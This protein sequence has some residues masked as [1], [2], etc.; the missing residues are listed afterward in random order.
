MF[1]VLLNSGISDECDQC[2]AVVIALLGAKSGYF[3]GDA[4]QQCNESFYSCINLDTE[5]H[6]SFRSGYWDDVL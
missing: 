2:G 6:C 5:I 1:R 4:F 3:T